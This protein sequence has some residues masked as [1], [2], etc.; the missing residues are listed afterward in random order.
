[1]LGTKF[2]LP[3]FCGSAEECEEDKENTN[4]FEV[5]LPVREEAVTTVERFSE[6]A[7]CGKEVRNR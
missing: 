5:R 6:V 4:R 7:R 3:G 1:M 2:P